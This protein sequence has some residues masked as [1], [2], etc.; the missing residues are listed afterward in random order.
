[1]NTDIPQDIQQ[2]IFRAKELLL[3]AK[4]AIALTGAGISTESGIPDFRGSGGIWEQFAP[5][6]YG[7]IYAFQKSPQLFWRLAKKIAPTLLHAKPNPGHYALA[8]L[9][10]IGII[11]AI[12]TQNIDGLHQKA[13]SKTVY[14]V[15][16]SLRK[17]T[18]TLCNTEYTQE[19]IVSSILRAIIPKCKLCNGYL[20]PNVV[21]FGEMLP[22]EEI[23]KSREAINK[24]DL[25]LV[26][27]SALEVS[28][29]NLLSDIVIGNG[30]NLII[31]NDTNTWL[32]DAA[33][34]VINHKTGII[35]PLI[36]KDIRSK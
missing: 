28:P 35:L 27:G 14:E 30:G 15:H 29:V 3:N 21:L 6:I 24:A 32:D 11:Q 22:E 16:G 26:A 34:L 7:N 4:Y 25:L 20:K 17:F 8:E 5:S 13:G 9:E 18:C 2:D 36:L 19:Y 10:K 1:M 33:E 23:E 31:L 12:I